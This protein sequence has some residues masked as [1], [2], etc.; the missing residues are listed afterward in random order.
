MCNIFFDFTLLCKLNQLPVLHKLFLG[1]SFSLNMKPILQT[2]SRYFQLYCCVLKRLQLNCYPQL[3]RDSA[4]GSVQCD[5]ENSLGVFWEWRVQ[6][7]SQ[8][9]A[10]NL[11]LI[12]SITKNFAQ[13][14]DG[15]PR[16]NTCGAR[17]A[18]RGSQTHLSIA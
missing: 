8:T 1:L 17:Q 5:T 4:L 10:P 18:I 2:T 15:C 11:K 3:L 12:C 7:F 16:I 13:P 6:S 14:I 9:S